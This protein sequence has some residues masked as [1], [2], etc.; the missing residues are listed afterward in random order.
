MRVLFWLIL[1]PKGVRRMTSIGAIASRFFAW[2]LSELGACV[3]GRLRR[4]LW[5]EPASLAIIPENGDARFTL[6][7]GGS[8]RD[9]GRIR[10]DPRVEPR[11]ALVQL[12]RGMSLQ[13]LDVVM[14][15]PAE[16][17]LRRSVSLPLAAAENL[18]EVLAF[19]MDRYTPFKAS[20]VAFDYQ[21]TSTDAE[22]KRLKV[23]LA[24]VPRGVLA[25]ATEI[26]ASFGLMLHRIGVAGEGLQ[27]GGSFNFLPAGSLAGRSTMQQ[28]L[29]IALMIL[30]TAL[31]VT[32]VY[33][34]LYAKERT[35]AAYKAQLAESRAAALEADALKERLMARLEHSRFLIDRRL[36]TPAATTLLAEITERLPDHTWLAQFRWQGNKLLLAGF[37]PAAAPLIAELEA[38]PLLTDVRFGSPVTADPRVG[39]ER[40]NIS[41][42]VAIP[43]GG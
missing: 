38:S 15:L 32:A 26:A 10:S 40:F 42:D 41:A 7:Q 13:G 21:V 37:S 19:E 2:W 25:Q 36:S 27:S 14:Q 8:P 35:L 16:L 23:D 3:P 17:V 20:E 4:F 34:P 39:H 33:L 9:L 24:V 43:P 12:L 30:A 18:R 1:K 31:A 29:L 6:H 22:S 28:R 5:R 11:R